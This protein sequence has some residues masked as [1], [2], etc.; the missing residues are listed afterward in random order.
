MLNQPDTVQEAS[1]HLEHGG[2]YEIRGIPLDGRYFSGSGDTVTCLLL[3]KDGERI[4]CFV[5]RN[6]AYQ[7]PRLQRSVL[8]GRQSGHARGRRALRSHRD[9]PFRRSPVRRGRR[10]RLLPAGVDALDG[11]GSRG[12]PRCSR[13]GPRVSRSSD[14]LLRRVQLGR[15]L[16]ESRPRRTAQ[17][18]SR[19]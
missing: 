7:D 5:D 4:R 17:P 13:R 16:R 9:E 10:S 1:Y 11:R 8:A 19:S 15:G 3:L 2:Q 14:T 18:F 6:I 12:Q